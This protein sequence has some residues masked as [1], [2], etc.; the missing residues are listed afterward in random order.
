[1]RKVGFSGPVNILLVDDDPADAGLAKKALQSWKNQ[2]RVF[3]VDDGEKCLKFLKREDE[4]GEA[5]RPNL[6]LLDLNMPRLNGHEVL[7]TIRKEES[8]RN[9]V[10]VVMTTSDSEIDVSLCYSRGANSYITK[11]V[12][13]DRFIEVVCNIE[14]YWLNTARIPH[15]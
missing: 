4:F 3:H 8:L 2:N 15:C 12:E 10:V 9:L 13:F 5:P 14:E 1:V 6:I 11:P 7:K